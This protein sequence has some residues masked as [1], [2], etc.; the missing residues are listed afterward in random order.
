MNFLNDKMYDYLKW[1]ALVLFPA[2]GTLYFA[3]AGVWGWGHADDVV[4]TIVAVDTFLGVVLGISTA[5]YN[6]D[7]GA[8]EGFI[9]ATGTDDVTGHP[10]LKMV[11]TKD[12]HELL[13]KRVVRL[14]VGEPPQHLAS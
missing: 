7:P 4:K 13:N 3:L 12:P 11:V 8:M 5:Q 9:H 14:K 2:L 6:R 1:A 10:Q